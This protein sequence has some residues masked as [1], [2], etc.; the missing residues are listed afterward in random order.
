MDLAVETLK[1]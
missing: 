1:G